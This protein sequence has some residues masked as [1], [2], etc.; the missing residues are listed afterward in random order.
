VKS[1]IWRIDEQG[2][3]LRLGRFSAK[4]ELHRPERGLIDLEVGP[5][6]LA[7]R[8]LLGVGLPPLAE[9]VERG[10]LEC[11]QRGPDLVAAYRESQSWPVRVDVLW[12][13]I[14]PGEAL[15]LVAGMDVIVSVR[16]ELLDSWPEL[17]V[18]SE[19]APVETLRLVDVEAA[20]FQPCSRESRSPLAVSRGEPGCFAF[21]L[22]D[23][24]LTYAEM[25]HP[26]DFFGA[27]VA[28]SGAGP[29]WLEVRHRLFAERLEKGV[30]LRS[31]VRGA[32]VDRAED[33]R[34]IAACYAAFAA[35]EPPLGT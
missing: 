4:V 8:S 9:G 10:V 20:R 35:A 31:R 26:A 12:R 28:E 33:L 1:L 7:A 24:P 13:A 3:S 2:A 22:P 15:G 25:G 29:E 18:R 30:I 27:V 5:F 6:A 23:V 14:S 21:R 11:Y 34:S 17:A 19:L 16:T 32:V